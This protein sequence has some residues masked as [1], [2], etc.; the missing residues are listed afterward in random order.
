MQDHSFDFRFK[1][2]SENSLSIYRELTE[3]LLEISRRVPSGMLVVCP[4]FK[5]LR[6]LKYHVNMRENL[7]RMGQVKAQIFE[8]RGGERYI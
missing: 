6:E 8:E 2:L 3:T 1:N 5:I 7:K 4:N